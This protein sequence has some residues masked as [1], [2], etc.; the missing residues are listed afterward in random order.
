MMKILQPVR[1]G[2]YTLKNRIVMA[3]METRLNTIQGDVTN[4][5]VDYYAERARGGA[6]AI[7]VEN[8]FVDNKE[9]RSSLISSGLYNDHLIRGKNHLAEAIQ[10]NGALA[11]LQL[12]HGGRQANGQAN[13]LQ[14]VAPSAVMCTV[15]QR[16]PRPLSVPEITEI[17]DAFAQAARRAKQAGFDGVEIHAAHG[18]LLCSFLSPYTNKRTD[19]Y[20]GG[21]ENRS[22]ILS[23]ILKKTRE[24]VGDNFIVG[25]RISGSEF[26]EGGITIEDSCSLLPLIEDQIDYIHVSGSIY[27]TAAL[28]NIT[29]MYMPAGEFIPFARAVKQV[30]SVPVITVGSLNAQMGEQVLEDGDADIIALGRPLIAD[31]YLPLKLMKN[32]P[33]DIRPCCRGNEGCISR[34]Y[35]GQ[36]IRCEVNPACGREKEYHIKKTA[37]PKKIVIA[38]GGIAGMEAARVADLMGHKVIL[39]EKTGQLGGHL[40]EGGAPD[41]KE[42]TAGFLDW[43]LLQI[44]KSHVDVRLNTAATP[45]LV[46]GLNPDAFIVAVGSHYADPPIQGIGLAI[47]ADKALLEGVGGQRVAVIGGGLVGAETALTL[48]EDGKDVTIIEM[49]PDIVPEHEAG[50][51]AAIKFRLGE[52]NVNIYTSHKVAE[53]QPGNVVCEC[54]REVSCDVVVNATGLTANAAEADNLSGV[55]PDTYVIG[56]CKC[57]RRIY[58]ATAEAWKTV[59]DIENS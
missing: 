53:I 41:F 33:R 46:T 50:A 27:E 15:T 40:I 51:Q 4:E 55:V 8:T 1:V 52:K 58:D 11:I 32:E 44:K 34:F 5:L 9:S 14:P 13:P 59:F 26:V 31:P 16:M 36:S 25:V 48:A 29:S 42:R 18:Y 57:A 24:L 3:P 28:H 2:S 39:L 47:H 7:I 17:E 49:L 6:A 12:S 30:T 22:R 54:G 38:G 37:N 56:D 21:I 10:E 45:G 20:G 35:L 43:L 23:N 19:E